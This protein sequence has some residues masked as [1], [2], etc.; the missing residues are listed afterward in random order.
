MQLFHLQAFEFGT[1]IRWS[2]HSTSPCSNASRFSI[3]ISP[4][5][6]KRSTSSYDASSLPVQT[7]SVTNENRSKGIFGI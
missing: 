7:A 4:T 5:K 1:R 3:G 2:I 6:R